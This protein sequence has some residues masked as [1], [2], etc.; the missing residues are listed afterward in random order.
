TYLERGF[1]TIVDVGTRGNIAAAIRDSIAEG[2]ILGPR[3]VASGQVIS[4][5]GGLM[6]NYPEWVEVEN[7]NG[8]RTD[9]LEN[10]RQE[11]RRQSNN[12][13]DASKLGVT[14]GMASRAREWLLLSEAEVAVVVDEAQRRDLL[15]G[16]HVFGVRAVT[17]AAR[18]G[19]RT[20]HHAFGGLSA[21]T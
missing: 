6:N 5:T 9:G 8:A 21:E 7:T 14:G 15:T 18:G 4:S 16:A 3:V 10:L 2:L 12:G 1:T 11:V 17:A 20:V 19:I 13:G